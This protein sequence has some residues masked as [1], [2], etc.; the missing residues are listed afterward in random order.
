MAIYRAAKWR[1][2]YPSLSPTLHLDTKNNGAAGYQGLEKIE[3][4]TDTGH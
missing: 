2:K 4:R 3:P 1:G